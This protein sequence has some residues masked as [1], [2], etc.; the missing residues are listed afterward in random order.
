MRRGLDRPLLVVVGLLLLFGLLTLYSA[1]QTD[2]PTAA[3]GAWRR[4][5]VWIGAGLVVLFVAS[6]TSP[7]LLEWGAPALYLFSLV[8]LVLTLVIGT[9]TGTAAGTRSWIAI[10][11]VR[12]GQPSELA[13]LALILMLARYLSGRRNAPQTLRELVLPGILAGVPFLLVMAQPDLGSA[14]VFVGIFFAMV[15]WAGTPARLLF[16]IASPV[17]SLLLAFNTTIWGAWMVGLLALLLAWRPYAIEAVTVYL[18]NSA[19]GAVAI[20]LWKR[21]A[22]YQQNRLL[23]FLNPEVDPQNAGYQAIQSKNAIGSGGWLG[24]GFT[25]GPQKR[26][27]FLPEQYTDFI[28]SVVGEELGFVGVAISL[29]LFLVLFFTLIRVARRATDPFGSLVAFGVLGL[30]FTHVFENVGM[31]VN[32]MPITGIPLP[33]FS[34]GGSFLLSCCLAV[35]LAVRVARDSRLAG[36][37]E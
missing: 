35:G 37:S 29:G 30:L 3:T 26:L 22:P 11:G 12:I 31:T 18:V 25:E 8:L 16:L 6:R 21:L 24:H 28:Y 19:M 9:G 15:F 27:A 17:I 14:L 33:F 7:R 23:T 36:Y 1:G 13:K 2:V 34:Y 4:Q 20:P 32:V 5:L 10:G